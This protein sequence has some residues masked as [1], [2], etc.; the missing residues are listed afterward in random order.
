MSG[1]STIVKNTQ[2]IQVRS[3]ANQLITR[4]FYEDVLHG[5]KEGLLPRS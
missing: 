4:R 2:P 3:V 1:L 5:R